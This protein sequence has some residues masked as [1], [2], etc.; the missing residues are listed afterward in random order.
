M[1][2]LGSDGLIWQQVQNNAGFLLFGW[3]SVAKRV[4]TEVPMGGVCVGMQVAM[5]GGLSQL[6]C[7]FHG[8]LIQVSTT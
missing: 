8:E 1:D 5:V 7:I 4:E 6:L 3:N 2:T